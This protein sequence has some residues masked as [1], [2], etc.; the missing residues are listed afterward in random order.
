MG[1]KTS[2]FDPFPKLFDRSTGLIIHPSN[3]LSGLQLLKVVQE[4]AKIA[5]LL[6]GLSCF[7]LCLELKKR[8]KEMVFPLVT[9]KTVILP[10]LCREKGRGRLYLAF[11]RPSIGQRFSD[12]ALHHAANLFGLFPLRDRPQQILHGLS[13]LR[14]VLRKRLFCLNIVKRFSFWIDLHVR[15]EHL[16]NACWRNVGRIIGLRD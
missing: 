7:V 13:R 15:L 3:G 12:K 5:P 8:P 16:G 2:L 10:S 11:I 4:N 6:D 14:V 9:E 1:R